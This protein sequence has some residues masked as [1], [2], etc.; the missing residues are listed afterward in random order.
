M[1][2]L[3]SYGTFILN[4]EAAVTQILP[5]WLLCK[6]ASHNRRSGVYF[7]PILLPECF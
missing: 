7:L 1:I 2:D 6:A 3:F 5:V 4:V